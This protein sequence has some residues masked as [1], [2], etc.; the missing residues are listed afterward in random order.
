M[1]GANFG[2]ISTTIGSAGSSPRVRGEQV[3]PCRPRHCSRI[4]PA[5]AGRTT[6]RPSSTLAFPDHPRVC[7]ANCSTVSAC[8]RAIGSS[9]RVRGERAQSGEEL[10]CGR[11]IPACA[12]RTD[13]GQA[14]HVGRADHPRVCGANYQPPIRLNQGDGSSPRVRGE[15]QDGRTILVRHRIIPACAGRTILSSH[16]SLRVKDHPRVCGANRSRRARAG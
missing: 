9:P 5:C 4:I 1:C 15:Q 10:T 3:Q 14:D 16:S 13:S 7:G 12:G 8:S 6:G 11:I 2:S